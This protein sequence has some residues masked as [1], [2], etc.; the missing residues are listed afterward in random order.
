MNKTLTTTVPRGTDTQDE[1]L[2]TK[3]SA[4]RHLCA[5]VYVDRSFRDLIIRKI[6]ND[7][8][9]R[10]APSYG[11]DLVPVVRHAWRSWLLD[12]GQLLAMLGILIAGLLMG[13]LL[14]TVIVSCT[15]L[16]C[17]LFRGITRELPKVVQGFAQRW[18]NRLGID[19]DTGLTNQ[20]DKKRRLKAM[21][22]CLL[23]VTAVPVAWSYFLDSP[24]TSTV[25]PAAVILSGFAACAVVAGIARK[26]LLNGVARPGPTRP[27]ALT[28]RETTIDEQQNHPCVIYQRPPHRDDDLDPLELLRRTDT[29]S[30]FFGSGKFVNQW[31]PPLTVQLLRPGDGSME[32]REYTTPPFTAHELVEALRVALTTLSTD[33]G[34]EGL[35]R[36]RV[37][38]RIYIAASDFPA[39]SKLIH[40]GL[41]EHEI[42]KIIDTHH[43]PRHHFLETSVPIFEGELVATVLIRV[44]LKG[45]SLSLDVATCA[46]TRTPDSYHVIYW[47][48]E[49]RLRGL[50]R[51]AGRSFLAIPADVTR[52]WQLI[53]APAVVVRAWL[54][55]KDYT[56][57]PRRKSVGPEI[58]VREEV[59]DSWDNARL[60]RSTI[61]DHMKIVEQRILKATEDFLRAHGVD[62]SV[63]DKQA[64][65]IINSGVLN[66][67]G[68]QMTVGQLAA[69]V[70]AHIGNQGGGEGPNT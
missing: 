39:G 14:A 15:V 51:S 53:K 22:I 58:A 1:H 41:E 5:G 29:P 34:E 28:R 35:P 18:A 42:R 63:F 23:V 55:Q 48:G 16:F 38:D 26:V 47:A 4:T 11:F 17:R 59:A 19:A 8:R 2:D 64:T 57:M 7:S 10:I 21:F 61:Y 6:H 68:S 24:I 3:P 70:G 32:E 54:A 65:N 20:R 13:G 60:D 43:L 27:H 31:L 50:L 69:G 9:H 46:L 37:R 33:P 40:G 52:I 67:G 25:V 44:S 12:T 62:T 45:R 30:P 49:Q 36:L 66:M 56:A